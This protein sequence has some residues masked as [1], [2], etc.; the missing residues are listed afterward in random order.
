MFQRFGPL[1]LQV[2]RE[3]CRHIEIGE[4]VDRL[5]PTLAKHVPA[6]FLV[7]RY[8]ELARSAL[9]TVAIGNCRA[10][11]VSLR[12]RSDCTPAALER[13]THW[14]RL[15]QVLR[16]AAQTINETLTALLPAGLEGDVLA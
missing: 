12:P 9:E 3:V 1:L 4:S 7:V 6:D 2:W 13:I 11:D 5:A 16:A 10:S 14:C 15:Q 8:I